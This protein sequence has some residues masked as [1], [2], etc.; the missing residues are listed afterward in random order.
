MLLMNKK[1]H[2]IFDGDSKPVRPKNQA[3]L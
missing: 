1:F 3:N 2:K